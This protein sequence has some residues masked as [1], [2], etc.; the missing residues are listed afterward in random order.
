M[1][2]N[3][4][5]GVYHVASTLLPWHS[6]WHLFQSQIDVEDLAVLVLVLY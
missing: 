3:D 4:S 5:I 6:H 2:Q 1:S